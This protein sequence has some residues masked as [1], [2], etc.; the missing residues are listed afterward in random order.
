M[1]E[2]TNS[3]KLCSPTA[4][5][6][7]TK[8]TVNYPNTAEKRRVA[9]SFRENPAISCLLRSVKGKTVGPARLASGEPD[10]NR[11]EVR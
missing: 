10:H 9:G 2:R 3:G 11:M 7:D 5:N 6:R 4:G 1:H 8:L